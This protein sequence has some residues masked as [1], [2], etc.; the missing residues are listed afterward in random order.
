MELI[1]DLERTLLKKIKV[2]KSRFFSMVVHT[3]GVHP[4]FI[5]SGSMVST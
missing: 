2:L 1:N 5:G 4:F 3:Q